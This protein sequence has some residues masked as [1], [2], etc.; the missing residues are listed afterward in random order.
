MDVH[1][2]HYRQ[3][4]DMI[5]RVDVAKILLILDLGLVSKYRGRKLDD[6]QLNGNLLFCS[7]QIL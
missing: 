6:I 1:R 7:A 2:V 4:S 5:E 3:T